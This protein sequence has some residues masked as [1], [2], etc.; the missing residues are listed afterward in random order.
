[1]KIL[2]I[3]NFYYPNTGGIEQTA[4]DLVNCFAEEGVEKQRVLCADLSSKKTR[5]YQVDGISV[6]ACGTWKRLFSQAITPDYPKYLKKHMDQ[7]R[8]DVVVLHWPNPYHVFFLSRYYKR[9]FRFVLYWHSDIIKQKILG[10]MLNFLAEQ[11]ADRAN[12]IIATS[13]DYI[14]GS[15]ILRKHRDKVRVVPSCISME[16]LQITE[17]M[18]ERSERIRSAKE[19][20]GKTILFTCGRHVPYKG[21]NFL[22][23]A[24]KY[25]DESYQIYIGGKGPETE[26]LMKL[27]E[28]DDKIH[29]LGFMNAEEMIAYQLACDIFCFPSI[30]KNEA[31]GLALAEG[32]YFGHPVVTFTI[33]GSGVNYVSLDGVTGLECPNGDSK[34]YAEAIKKLAT[35]PELKEKLGQ[36]ARK[37]VLENFTYERYK[38][39]VCD[40]RIVSDEKDHRY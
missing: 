37:R 36:A 24:S 32:M 12:V 33:D 34:A 19:N 21:L 39:N 4:R 28:G 29:F 1:M 10:K 20:Q 30:T 11:A 13:P 22:I 6:T 40:R 14:E 8:P 5:H 26:R 16:E 25:L 17:Q 3:P 35:D 23:E 15:A 2:H 27:A 18:R 9:K 31:F 7:Y 38:E